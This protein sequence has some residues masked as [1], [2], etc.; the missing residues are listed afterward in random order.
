MDRLVLMA[1]V[2][3]G[4]A[5]LREM[6][7]RAQ[8]IGRLPD[9]SVPPQ[10]QDSLQVGGFRMEAAFLAD[11]AALDL[12][13]IE[14]PPAPRVLLL[15]PEAKALAARLEAL[16]CAVTVGPFP[17]LAQL[18]GDPIFASVPEADFARVT[19][20]AAEAVAMAAVPSPTLSPPSP[21]AH[22][23]GPGWVE[24]PVRSVP[25]LFG[26]RCGPP[27]P[28]PAAPTVL[29]VST[30]MTV[31]SGWGRQTTNLAR[32][33]AVQ[34]VPSVRFDLR[35]IG[36][37]AERPDDRRPLFAPEGIADVIA[38]VDHAAGA[39]GPIV[40]VGGCSGAYAAF[41][42]LCR[43]SR[44]DGA[45][46]INLYGFDW[47]PDQDLDTVIRQTFGSVNTYAGLLAQGST[48][49]RL[50]TGRIHVRAIAGALAGG[51]PKRRSG[52]CVGRGGPASRVGP[53]PGASLRSGAAAAISACSTARAIP[54]WSRC[55]AISGVPRAGQS[56]TSVPR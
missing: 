8:T 45:L 21:P 56:G 23:A 5:Y 42:A 30:G 19:A 22:L 13:R 43:D 27:I 12:V 15:A 41:Q 46:L 35:G 14:R 24:V 54:G 20:F 40:L 34:G 33:L 16:G 17:G 51:P 6:R 44:I 7:L 3:S 25:G 9:G 38:A 10:E 52:A 49:R 37:G 29:F 48:W 32:S 1:P 39:G 18:V 31:R 4:R 26:I 11:L 50:L 28:D 36:D 55:A 2:G 47:D 53:S